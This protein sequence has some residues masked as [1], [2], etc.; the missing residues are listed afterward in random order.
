MSA[1][2]PPTEASDLAPRTRDAWQLV[3]TMLDD[4]TRIVEAE[5][6]SRKQP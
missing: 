2:E 1:D 5:G 6:F 4:L 3:R